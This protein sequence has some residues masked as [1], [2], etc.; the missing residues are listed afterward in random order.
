MRDVTKEEIEAAAVQLP[1]HYYEGFSATEWENSLG[2][3]ESPD[4]GD[5]IELIIETL[6]AMDEAARARGSRGE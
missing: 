6:R 2:L 5:R 4:D 3:G 1:T